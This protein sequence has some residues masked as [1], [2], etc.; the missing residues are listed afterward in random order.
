MKL[1]DLLDIC[2]WRYAFDKPESFENFLCRLKGHPHGPVYFNVG[3]L[4][5]DM[6]CRDCGE[7]L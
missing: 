1:L 7:E 6:S 2:I 5:P 4:E 3:G